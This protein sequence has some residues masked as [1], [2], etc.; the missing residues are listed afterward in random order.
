MKITNTLWQLVTCAIAGSVLLSSC[1]KESDSKGAPAPS[2]M[3]QQD[4]V[5]KDGILVFKDRKTMKNFN[6]YLNAKGVE[7]ANQWEKSLN[8]VSM[9]HILNDVIDADTKLEADILKGKSAD[10]VAQLQKT[11]APHTALYTKWVNAGTLRVAKDADG[12]ETLDVNASHNL[13]TN[14]LNAEGIVAFGDTVYQF[15]GHNMKVTTKGLSNLDALRSATQSDPS[16]QITVRKSLFPDE[17]RAQSSNNSGTA[18][19]IVYNGPIQQSQYQYRES[20]TDRKVTMSVYFY[21]NLVDTSLPDVFRE[22]DVDFWYEAK[23]EY[24]SWGSWRLRDN[25]NGISALTA[26]YSWQAEVMPNPVT[27]PAVF[28]VPGYS[29]GY[30]NP[31][32]SYLASSRPNRVKFDSSTGSPQ[33]GNQT[34]PNGRYGYGYFGATFNSAD[35]PYWSITRGLMLDRNSIFIAYVGS[36]STQVTW[37]Y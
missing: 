25:G 26:Q 8:F 23:A 4:V 30:A 15:K 7:Y 1:E 3:S 14:V 33:F 2:V 17:Q 34:L 35:Y 9:A 28:T 21:S 32:H 13:F 19:R 20:S 12:T 24:K 5:V 37:N 31:D 36:R 18:N 6:S 29:T 10:E 27:S 11:P 22:N 16:R